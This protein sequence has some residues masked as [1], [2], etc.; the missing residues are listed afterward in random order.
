MDILSYRKVFA[1]KEKR[2]NVEESVRFSIMSNRFPKTNHRNG[3]PVKLLLAAIVGT[4]FVFFVQAMTSWTVNKHIDSIRSVHSVAVE[5]SGTLVQL[6]TA[7]TSSAKLAASTGDLHYEAVYLEA[8][9]NLTSVFNILQPLLS[10]K[11]RATLE[12]VAA[13]NSKFVQIEI[14][15]F[16]AVRCGEKDRAMTLLASPEYMRAKKQ[17]TSG[18][19]VL[20]QMMLED[21]QSL[22]RDVAWTVYLMVGGGG[23]SAFIMILFLVIVY[24]RSQ[25]AFETRRLAEDEAVQMRMQLQK[26]TAQSPSTSCDVDTLQGQGKQKRTIQEELEVSNLRFSSVLRNMSDGLVIYEAIDNGKDFLIIEFNE[27]AERIEQISRDRVVGH[28]VTQVFPGIKEFGLFDVLLRVYKTGTPESFPISLYF[29]SRHQS[30]RENLVFRLP[31]RELVVIY[32][33][34]TEKRRAEEAIKSNEERLQLA[35]HGGTVG[36]WDWDI[37]TGEVIFSDRWAEIIGFSLDEIEPSYRTWET[38]LHPDDRE[39]VL[40]ALADHFD[41]KTSV[42]ECEHRIWHKD[43]LWQWVLGIGKLSKF[44]EDMRPLRMTGV[45]LDISTRKQAEKRLAESE[46]RFRNV[47]LTSADWIWETDEQWRFTYVSEMIHN[48]LGFQP[49]DVI[50]KTPYELMP[51]DTAQQTEADF[52]QQAQLKN[53]L[54]DRETWY[55]T[56]SG[57]KACL[58]TNAVPLFDKAGA[59]T[60]YFG[61]NKNITF[62]KEAEK[63]LKLRLYEL[64]TL[65]QLSKRISANLSLDAVVKSAI[66][67]VRGPIDPD[68]VILFLL[69]GKELT[70]HEIHADKIDFTDKHLLPGEFGEC[71]C[72]LAAKSAKPVYSADIHADL[73]CTHDDCKKA[74]IVSYAAIPIVIGDEVVGVLGI[75]SLRPRDFSKQSEFIESMA[76]VISTGINNTLLHQ[77]VLDYADTLEMRVTER[78]NELNQEIE[79]RRRVEKEL[80]FA[81]NQ[82]EAANTAKSEF[83]AKMSHEIRTPMNAIINMSEYTL[84]LDPTNEQ[85]EGIEIIRQAGRHLLAV[86]NDIL[87]I[88]KVEAGKFVLEAIPFDLVETLRSTIASLDQQARDKGLFLNLET[89]DSFQRYFIGDPVRIQQILINLVGNSIKFTEKGGV[90]VSVFCYGGVCL[91]DNETSD[92]LSARLGFAIQDTGIGIPDGEIDRI[93]E[94]FS[95]VDSATTR[96][97]GGTGLGLAITKQLVEMMDG[98]LKVRSE[99]GK[100][101]TFSFDLNLTLAR[102]DQVKSGALTDYD[103]APVQE[104]PLNIL[105]AEDNEE[106]I[107]VAQALIGKL[108][109][110][111]VIVKNGQDAIDKLKVESFDLVFMDLEMPIMDGLEATRRIRAGEAGEKAR[112][113]RIIALTAHAF[114]EYHERCIAAGMDSYLSK[115]FSF[116]GLVGLLGQVETPD[117]KS[118]HQSQDSEK[119]LAVLDSQTALRRFGDDVELYDEICSD[120]LGFIP[121]KMKRFKSLIDSGNLGELVLL[122]HSFKGNCAT[123]GADVCRN[124]A[125]QIEVAAREGRK[126]DVEAL[127]PQFLDDVEI[128]RSALQKRIG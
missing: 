14:D 45:M 126:Q 27:A 55:W 8:E 58:L 63:N 111:V 26:Q 47:I 71:L 84:L 122:V 125:A 48:I 80:V 68:L 109:H 75:G 105:I 29:D 32:S 60:G 38:R 53:P 15:A 115:P 76:G 117:E 50:G 82:A 33:D 93:F 41:G 124:S 83:L 5:L 106:N 74:G 24:R 21:S 30:W 104:K 66:E 40:G 46:Q 108:G 37:K 89:D 119:R 49:E 97:Y 11:S 69:Q 36:F 42:F 28:A 23:V 1:T 110:H 12:M 43:G 77:Q 121:G 10:A 44:D 9:K 120:F 25:H 64:D 20:D 107:K 98:T 90:T 86:I 65:N 114:A 79:E 100:G 62:R 128:L 57:D 59:L 67:G 70:V 51:P 101:S 85:R 17:Y 56:S 103:E 88:S 22:V 31:T 87:D 2:G 81:K 7:L 92:V 3:F 78:T 54:V 13:A 95:Q 52:T 6:D 16:D 113:T 19:R 123:V 73:R 94:A 118:A 96:R 35:M 18:L 127:F 61:I 4:M 39:R 116:Q 91:L 102:P 112:Q 99:I 34:V 72:G